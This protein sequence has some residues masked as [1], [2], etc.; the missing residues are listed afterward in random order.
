[1]KVSRKQWLTE[2]L[3]LLGKQGPEALK[4]D[5]LCRQLK[6]SKGSFYHHFSHR[7][8]YLEALLAYWQECNTENVI[9][10]LESLST[11]AKR[12]EQFNDHIARTDLKAEIEL[13]A[14]GRQNPTVGN[15]VARVDQR[16][17]NYLTELITGQTED[18][19]QAD[20]IARVVYAQF[21]GCQYLQH[22]ISQQDWA[23]M[24]LLL[25]AMV[26]HY[27]EAPH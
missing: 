1:M 5:R 21:V 25:Q 10:N 11:P 15:A 27:L 20:T 3:K 19:K 12:G 23:E 26:Q 8:N 6:V 22:S 24:D 13:R 14:W 7:E 17:M 16:R 2:G 4:I 18:Q 9:E